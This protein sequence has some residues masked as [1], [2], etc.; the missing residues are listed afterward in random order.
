MHKRTRPQGRRKNQ[1]VSLVPFLM[2]QLLCH[3][4]GAFQSVRLL[5][6]HAT[7]RCLSGSL[8]D[9]LGD[10]LENPSL[11][12]ETILTNERGTPQECGG[13]SSWKNIDWKSASRTPTNLTESP[14]DVTMILDKVVHIKRDDQLRLPGS[15]ISGNKA[16]KMFALNSLEPFPRSLVSYGGPQSNAML[17]L[18]A[19]VHFQNEKFQNE[20]QGVV[21][22][23]QDHRRFV[24]YTKPLPRFL[25]KQPSGNL[26]RARMLGMELRELP[27]KE[28]NDLFGGDTGGSLAPPPLLKPPDLVESVWIPQGGACEAAIPGTRQL[29]EAILS[30]WEK[31]GA[32][33]PLSV[34]LPGGTCSTAALLH[35]AVRE[36][37]E[38]S[39]E[40]STDV[41]VVV[42]PCVGDASY[43]RRQM[44]SLYSQLNIQCDLPRV[45]SPAPGYD[46]AGDYFSFGEPSQTILETFTR[47]RDEN[48]L[49]LDLLYGAPSWTI[50]L[51][52]LRPDRRN[53]SPLYGRE[54]MYVHSGGL[55]GIN[56]QLLRYKYKGLVDIDDIQ[57]PGRP[58]TDSA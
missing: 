30:Y 33:R 12:N 9:L 17:A 27:H 24:Y 1:A 26:F 49:V 47:M 45:L 53:Q 29:A 21:E 34:V 23:G 20:K 51:R 25:R 37:V 28:Y 48:D 36:A 15:Q 13:G 10:L 4:S 38:L 41:Q 2:Q 11:A 32:G 31:I 16:R 58:G 42:I 5:H 3:A 54:I 52:H 35:W 44:S 22:N 46:G 18:A 50:L 57:L 7:R 43:A 6:R 40:A 8:D 56:S 39:K 19:V 14:V 55:E